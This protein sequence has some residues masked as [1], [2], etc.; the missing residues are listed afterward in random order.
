MVYIN[1]QSSKYI[2]VYMQTIK[3]T[4]SQNIDIDYPLADLG[5][6]IVA[7]L[8]DY[9][10]FMGL[11]IVVFIILGVFVGMN[12]NY[13]SS[14][15]NIGIFVIIGV[16]GILYIFY[17]LVCEIFMNGQSIGKR[18]MKIKV[19]SL[20]GIRPTVGQYLLRWFFRIIDFGITLGSGA[21]IC[22]I[23]T[24]KKQ[25]IGDVVAGTTVISL[26]DNITEFVFGEPPA[27]YEPM[28]NQVAL[29]TD[30]DVV[31]IHDVIRNFN[32]TRN[33]GLVYKLAIQ[34]KNY[35]NISYTSE[36]NEY[37]F[38]EIVLNDYNTMITKTTE[39]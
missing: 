7:R 27:G 32:H 23:V 24:Y 8:I 1:I 5:T 36:I 35:L 25:R 30:H 13:N 20:N 39:L 14:G 15:F 21:L 4:T 37:Q 22:D 6:R 34:L 16:W 33:S 2:F 3:I 17:D 28:Y 29:L 10:V 9:G 31:L 38:L 26:K 19:I 12:N 11:Y 18:A